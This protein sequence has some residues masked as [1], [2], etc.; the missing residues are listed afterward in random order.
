MKRLTTPSKNKSYTV[1][2]SAIQP[3]LGG[4]T[5]E[6]IDKLAGFENFY[7]AI[8]SQQLEIEKELEKLRAQDKSRTV[9]FKQ[10]LA[11]K[12]SN[13]NILIQLKTYGIE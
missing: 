4:Y 1:E 10:L 2:E 11:N 3:A 5:G 12:L 8:Q 13:N 6:A 9:R 7:E